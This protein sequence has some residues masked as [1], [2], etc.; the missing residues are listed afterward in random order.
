MMV[1]T[2]FPYGRGES[3]VHAE[4]E[5]VAESFDQVTIV[6]CFM[7]PEAPPR[8]VAHKVELAY[9][10]ARWGSARVLHV[11]S[12]FFGA[13]WRY[14]WL[15]EA[16][17]VLGKPHRLENVKELV[18]SLYRARLF[19]QFLDA[20][21]RRS[22]QV[23]LIY[24]YWIIPEIAGALAFRRFSARAGAQS[25]KIVARAHGGDL[26]EEGRLGAYAGLTRDIIAGLD[27]VYCISVHG[28]AYLD[29]KYPTMA[30]KF[31]L[32]RLGVDDPG[33]INPQP[34][35]SHLSI[36]SCSFMV[37]GKRLHLIAQAIAF[38]VDQH[39]GLAVRWTHIG[40]GELSEQLREQ[41]QTLFAGTSVEVDF[42]GYMKQPALVA[43]YR[44]AAFDVIVNVSDTE[45][46]PVSLMEAS[47]VGIP[48]VATDVGGSSEIVNSRN[49]VL[50]N[51]NANIAE[52]ATAILNFKDKSH[53][54]HYRKQARAYWQSHF[55]ARRNYARFAQMLLREMGA[56]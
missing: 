23:D 15:D 17:L 16:A 51:E 53:A 3:F 40:D 32:A 30:K 49:G 41:V 24:F 5:T 7:T 56:P 9:A 47:S 43:F 42:K 25:L 33:F 27:A 37:P 14:K 6:P 22:G 45:G 35:G 44:E 39:P 29:K 18:R 46:I 48:M 52:I 26:Y 4:L 8:D 12:S 11:A 38:L 19:E 34:D 10:R 36:L 21:Q 31:H 2:G 54:M 20:H 13:L 55:D 1:T 50:I 28:K